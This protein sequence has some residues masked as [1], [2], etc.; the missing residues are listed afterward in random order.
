MLLSEYFTN[1]NYFKGM[2]ENRDLIA[3]IDPVARPP[4]RKRRKTNDNDGSPSDLCS[5][6]NIGLLPRRGR[7]QFLKT[8]AE[9]RAGNETGTFSY[10]AAV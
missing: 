10:I 2:A 1:R 6:G 9:V 5:F 8:K 4:S 3:E 7:L